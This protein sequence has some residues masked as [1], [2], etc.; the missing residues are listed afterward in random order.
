MVVEVLD[1]R[2]RLQERVLRHGEHAVPVDVEAVGQ[3]RPLLRRLRAE[4]HLKVTLEQPGVSDARPDPFVVFR[5][6]DDQP[7]TV[8]RVLARSDNEEVRKHVGRVRIFE[9]GK[10]HGRLVD[11]RRL[12]GLRGDRERAR[13]VLERRFPITSCVSDYDRVWARQIET[14]D[15]TPW[16]RG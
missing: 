4:R 15:G 9:S 1:D 12:V 11:Q 16:R 5:V 13:Q 10:R 14:S 8:G 6:P 3:L 2:L 7:G